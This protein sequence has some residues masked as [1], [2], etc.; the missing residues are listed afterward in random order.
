MRG[1]YKSRQEALHILRN[2]G[3][4][5]ANE[6]RALEN[7]NPIDGEEGAAYLVNGNMIPVAL[8]MKGGAAALK[9]QPDPPGADQPK[10]DDDQ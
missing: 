9:P 4:I 6:W 3:V 8:A 7:M 5:S 10:G 2:D 1:D